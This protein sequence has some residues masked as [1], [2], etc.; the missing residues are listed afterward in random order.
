MR[1][2][3][4]T[5]TKPILSAH[6]GNN[7]SP[8]SR[9]EMFY[10]SQIHMHAYAPNERRPARV[11]LLKRHSPREMYRR[12]REGGHWQQVV[13]HLCP[14]A[15]ATGRLTTSSPSSA[16]YGHPLSVPAQ[17]MATLT[18]SS[19]DY[20]QVDHLSPFRRRLFPQHKGNRE[21]FHIHLFTCNVNVYYAK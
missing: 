2:W 10:R 16:D 4:S 17:T 14:S 20:G 13:D 15:Q 1:N 8:S 21:K 3:T 9:T 7:P 18:R 6:V 5:R 12:K 19:A 11:L